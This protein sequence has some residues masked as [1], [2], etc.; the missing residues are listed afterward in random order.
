MQW[1]VCTVQGK[2]V[3]KIAI[4]RTHDNGTCVCFIHLASNHQCINFVNSWHIVMTQISA[5]VVHQT[6]T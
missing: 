5:A 1:R 4:S 6:K 3:L 2:D